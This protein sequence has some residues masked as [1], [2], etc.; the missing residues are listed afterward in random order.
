MNVGTKI[1]TVTATDADKDTDTNG[2]IVYSLLNSTSKDNEYF[3]INNGEIKLK[4]KLDR[5]N[6]RREMKEL[7]VNKFKKVTCYHG[8]NGL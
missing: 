3:S 5:E 4:Q 6:E 1:L 7:K 2:K 8:K